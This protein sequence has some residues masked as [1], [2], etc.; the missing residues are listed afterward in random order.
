MITR[1]SLLLGILC[2]TISAHSQDG[3]YYGVKGGMT[4]GTQQWNSFDKEA[5]VAYHVILSAENMP[6]QDKFSLFAQVG[7]HVKGSSIRPRLFGNPF[8]ASFVSSPPR[9]FEFY[10]IALSVGA[11]QE[12]KKIGNNSAYYLFGIRGDFTVGTNLGDYGD[13]TVGNP[14]IAIFYPINSYDFIRRINYGFIAGGGINFPISEY[15]QGILEFTV[16]PDFS[17]QYQQPP[18]EHVTNPFNGQQTTI[19][20]RNIRNLTF[21]ITVGARFLRK[22]E[23][24]D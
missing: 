16:N 6:V 11:K 2:F 13:F 21:E 18:I 10:N 23:Y 17:L 14:S 1:L 4:L 15:V 24:I 9:K 3:T 5:L 12:V 19:A 7:Y 20:E 8:N 22:I